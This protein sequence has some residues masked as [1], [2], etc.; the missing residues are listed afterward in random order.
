LLAHLRRAYYRGATGAGAMGASRR[1]GMMDEM[2]EM[3]GMTWQHGKSTPKTEK[4]I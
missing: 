3:P 1:D 2:D 4:H